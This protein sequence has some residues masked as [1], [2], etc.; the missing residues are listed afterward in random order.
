MHDH[1]FE[2]SEWPFDFP[3]EQ[4]A[5]TTRYVMDGS[6]PVTAV[7]HDE[8]NDWQILCGTTNNPDDGMV[9]CMGCL[10]SKFPFLAD[11]KDLKPGWEAYRKNEKSEWQIHEI[12]WD[13][14]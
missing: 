1:S 2:E 7:L 13:D 12:E 9:V 5:I 8:E 11:F 10:Y 14:E 4:M 6:H 3:I